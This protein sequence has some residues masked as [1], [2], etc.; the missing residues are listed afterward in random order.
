MYLFRKG[1]GIQNPSY[2]NINR[3]LAQVLSSITGRIFLWIQLTQVLSHE[4]SWD[5]NHHYATTMFTLTKLRSFLELGFSTLKINFWWLWIISNEKYCHFLKVPKVNT[6]AI[7]YIENITF[8]SKIQ[9]HSKKL[10]NYSSRKN[11]YLE[12]WNSN[13]QWKKHYLEYFKSTIWRKNNYLEILL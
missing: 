9:N 5:N 3:L 7:H 6:E 11:Q 13:I 4:S 8:L 1:L 12:K 10:S 2:T